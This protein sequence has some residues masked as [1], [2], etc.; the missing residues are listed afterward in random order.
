MNKEKFEDY[1]S[2]DSH[3][4]TC[5]VEIVQELCESLVG[6][7]RVEGE[8]GGGEEEDDEPEVVPSFAETHE[9]LMKVR[10]FFYAHSTS[11]S[12]HESVLALKKSYIELKCKFCT[13]QISMKDF[14]S[15]K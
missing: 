2:V 15:K 14:F 9:A 3:V 4:A 5:G 7:G 8:E 1:V 10:S 11:D 12:D 13:K 6:S